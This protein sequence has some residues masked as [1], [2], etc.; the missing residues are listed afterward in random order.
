MPLSPCASTA[1]TTTGALS[2][3]C[4]TLQESGPTRCGDLVKGSRVCLGGRGS[5]AH[6]MSPAERAG[7]VRGI[8]SRTHPHSH[9]FMGASIAAQ[10]P[11]V[12]AVWQTRP[13]MCET[14]PY[15]LTPHS[16]PSLWCPMCPAPSPAATALQQP[17]PVQGLRR[18]QRVGPQRGE[19]T[20]QHSE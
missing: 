19:G 20:R 4:P 15:S 2:G 14:H 12:T 8:D 18:Q 10:N 5:L 17:R 9:G 3:T 6:R 16:G 13:H 7:I 1:P 11:S